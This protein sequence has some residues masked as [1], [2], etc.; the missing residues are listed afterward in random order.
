M[1]SPLAEAHIEAER[2]LRLLTSQTVGDIWKSLP[3]YDRQNVDQW[4]SEVLPVVLGAERQSAA[5]TEGY[6]ARA[7]DRLPE[8]VDV[9]ALIGAALRNGVPPAEVYERPFVNV[10]TALKDGRSFADAVE[11]GLARATSTAAMDVQLAMRSTASAVQAAD[12]SIFGYT[13]VADATACSFCLEV[14]GT[15]VKSADA[16]PLHNRCGCGLEPQTEPHRG[17]VLL[18]DGTQIREH[19]YGP[20]NDNIAIHL[21]GELGP[22]LTGAHDH[23]TSESEI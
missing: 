20:L 11:S 1:L 12:P 4:L 18:P 16:M 22:V 8:G 15:Y 17:A 19:A 21:H 9:D 7:L 6:I 23:F 5:L 10:W 3:G 13:R 14:D 2:R